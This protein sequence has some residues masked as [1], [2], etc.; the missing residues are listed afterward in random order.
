VDGV[1]R[2]LGRTWRLLQASLKDEA[3][4]NAEPTKEQLKLLHATIK[5]VLPGARGAG[6]AACAPPS[7]AAKCK[8][9]AEIRRKRGQSRQRRGGDYGKCGSPPSM[10]WQRHGGVDGARIGAALR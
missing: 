5:K 10:V 9:L 6:T 7:T 1:H 4:L 3:V 2:F 8:R